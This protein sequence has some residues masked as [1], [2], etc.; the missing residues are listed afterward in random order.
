MEITATTR[1][2]VSKLNDG[3]VSYVN[4]KGLK[5]KWKGVNAKVAIPYEEL[6]DCMLDGNNRNLF[7]HGYLYVE[8]K[9]VRIKLGLESEDPTVDSG[10]KRVYNKKQ[11]IDL[12]YKTA[13][14]EDF[15]R[16]VKNLAAASKDLLIA[17]AQ[18]EKEHA[19]YD[20]YEY[21][22]KLFNVDIEQLRKNKREEAKEA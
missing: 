14:I 7:D 22:N 10:L 5:R 8:D 20:K 17:V 12:L 21:I 4:A 11:I 15:K 1:C 3:V 6:E 18:D 19:G 9:Q 13:N 2:V 16:E